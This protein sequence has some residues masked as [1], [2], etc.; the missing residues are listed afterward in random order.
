MVENWTTYHLK[1][2]HTHTQRSSVAT[3][4]RAAERRCQSREQECEGESW[5]KR[6]GAVAR[7]E[8]VEADQSGDGPVRARKRAVGGACTD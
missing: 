6:V 5:R 8:R 2:T 3:E 7:L 4:E 1:Y